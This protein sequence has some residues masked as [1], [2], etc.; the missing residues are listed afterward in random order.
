MAVDGS[1]DLDTASRSEEFDGIRH[2]HI[3]PSAIFQ[4]LCK[5]AVNSLSNFRF[6]SWSRAVLFIV[7]VLPRCT[8]YRDLRNRVTRQLVL[9]PHRQPG[10]LLNDHEPVAILVA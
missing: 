4:A 6:S 1:P 2:H 3:G 8:D 10:R 7:G 5:V 9:A